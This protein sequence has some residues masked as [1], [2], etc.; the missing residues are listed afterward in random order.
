MY[1]V[2]I[3]NLIKS[4]QFQYLENENKKKKK[5]EELKQDKEPVCSPQLN[6]PHKNNLKNNTQGRKQLTTDGQNCG[7]ENLLITDEIAQPII[8]IIIIVVI[9]ITIVITM[10]MVVVVME[11]S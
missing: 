11:S 5:T 1:V 3:M 9:I 8:I 2:L 10:M 6:L 7:K 4:E